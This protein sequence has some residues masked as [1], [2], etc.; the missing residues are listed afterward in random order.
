MEKIAWGVIAL[1]L[2]CFSFTGVPDRGIIL[3]QTDQSKDLSGEQ[4]KISVS[5]EPMKREHGAVVYGSRVSHAKVRS[6]IEANCV[7]GISQRRMSSRDS[8]WEAK[9]RAKQKRSETRLGIGKMLPRLVPLLGIGVIL[10]GMV[11]LFVWSK[12]RK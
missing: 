10:V 12:K 5:L 6:M 11:F 1:W 2:V 7:M 3:Y 4:R 9:N 8:T